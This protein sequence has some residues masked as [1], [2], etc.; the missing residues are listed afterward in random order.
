ME[1]E[2]TTKVTHLDQDSTDSTDSVE[3]AGFD[4]KATKRLIRKIDLVLIPW[5]ALLYL[6]VSQT[7]STRRSDSDMRASA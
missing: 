1:E 5:L 2:K 3:S 7:S 6:C 4:Q